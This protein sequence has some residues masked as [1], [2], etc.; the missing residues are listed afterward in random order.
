[1]SDGLTGGRVKL[2]NFTGKT[3]IYSLVHTQ[4]LPGQT[5][6]ANDDNANPNMLGEYSLCGLPLDETY[7]IFAH[8]DNYLSY[9][10]TV[11]VNST[12]ASRT[13]QAVTDIALEAPT[14]LVNI[15]LYPIGKESKD[16]VFTVVYSG[17]PLAG[18]MVYLRPTGGNYL[19]PGNGNFYAPLDI[20]QQPLT[21][22]TDA[23]GVVTFPKDNLILGGHY[24][25]V[26]IPPN[27]GASQTAKTSA[28]T[29]ILGLRTVAG[30]ID[31]YEIYVDLDNSEGGVAEV[32]RST[33]KGDLDATGK[34]VIY[35]DRAIEV[36]PGTTDA[37]ASTLSGNVTASIPPA[38]ATN[39]A[40]EQVTYSIANNVLTLTPKFLVNPDADHTKEWGLAVTYSGIT[41]RPKD[42]P[43]KTAT[44]TITGTVRFYR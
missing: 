34:L 38:I 24:T 36:V 22:T 4:T 18:A 13:G 3:G 19:D 10:T 31:P 8:V 26:V 29:F 28:A 25:Y 35:F 43:L 33:D 21:G 5:I 32:S 27:G 6:V 42:L 41:I 9:E 30:A 1:M 40:T 23:N 16:L 11:H 44:L 2:P 37:M 17:A 7:P 39:D 15:R 20:R 12:I 14:E